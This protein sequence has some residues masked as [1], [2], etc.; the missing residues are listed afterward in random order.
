Y[1]DPQLNSLVER[2]NTSNQTVAQYE[3]PY[4]QAQ[5]LVR[6]SRCAF[7]P[8]LDLTTGKTRSGQSTGTSNTGTGNSVSGIRNSY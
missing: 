2:L 1:R 8:T 3:A 4:R 7:L 5:A 6:S